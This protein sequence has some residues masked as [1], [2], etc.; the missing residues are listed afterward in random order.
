MFKRLL[1][2]ALLILVVNVGLFADNYV[3]PTD[4]NQVTPQDLDF[5]GVDTYIISL[6]SVPVIVSSPT[7]IATANNSDTIL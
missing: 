6:T 3:L 7:Y 4:N 1:I 5:V 2:S